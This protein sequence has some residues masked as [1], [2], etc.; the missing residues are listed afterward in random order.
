MG[1]RIIKTIRGRID[2]AVTKGEDTMAKKRAAT[3]FIA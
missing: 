3:A 1:A 2:A